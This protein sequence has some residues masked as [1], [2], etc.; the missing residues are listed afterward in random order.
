MTPNLRNGKIALLVQK[1]AL[2]YTTSG[3]EM[4]Y[5]YQF[6]LLVMGNHLPASFC[7]A[8]DN[9]RKQVKKYT[10]V[11]FYEV[12]PI[13]TYDHHFIIRASPD[14]MI[15][16]TLCIYTGKYISLAFLHSMY[17][18]RVHWKCEACRYMS[19]PTL[20]KRLSMTEGSTP[21]VP[22]VMDTLYLNLASR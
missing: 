11:G 10:K 14:A 5:R 8:P 15:H 9:I 13:S 3:R 1:F 12:P 7:Q 17:I 16:E 19:F 20:G 6:C 18:W 22:S 4:H 21:R 2:H